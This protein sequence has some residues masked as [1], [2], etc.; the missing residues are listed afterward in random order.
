MSL[1]N[2]VAVVGVGSTAAG[3]LPGN[4]SYDLGLMAFKRAMDDCGLKPAQI[5]GLI[6]NRIPDYQR[7]AEIAGMDP[8]FALVT[9]GQG[10]MSGTSIEIAASVIA[11][12]LAHT[13]ALVYGNNGKSSG[14]RY[15]GESDRYGGGGIGPWFPYGMTSPGAAHAVMFQRHMHLYGTTSRQLG[16]VSVA[17]RKHAV[18][19]PDAV[20]RKSITIED[21]QNSR[22]IAEPLHLFDYCLINDG[23]VALIVTAAERARDFPKPPVYVRGFGVS[24]K[25]A[26]SSLPPEDF[27]YAPMQQAAKQTYAMAGVKHDDLDGLMIYDNF[28]P[29]VLFTLEGFGFCKVGE[30]GAFVQDGRL[31]LGGQYP[32]NTDGGHLSNSYM[33]GWALNAEAVRQLRGECGARQIKDAKLIQYMCAAPLCTSIIYGTDPQ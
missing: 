26:G 22:F 10:R 20:M 3:T 5:D 7:F 1:R 4:D 8:R 33:Q 16:A 27:W 32:S 29:T 31:E 9:P 21:H 13:V 14:D 11:A 12:G 2:R 28:S 6:V 17:F 19:N 23:S 18:L 30:S 25:L 24:T 15:G